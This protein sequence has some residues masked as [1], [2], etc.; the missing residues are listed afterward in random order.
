MQALVGSYINSM[1]PLVR[2]YNSMDVRY[3]WLKVQSKARL[4]HR[5]FKSLFRRR[6]INE[7]KV[8][9]FTFSQWNLKRASEMHPPR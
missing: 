5:G 6:L 4:N 7:K 1:S 9:A 8:L 3:I 2:V